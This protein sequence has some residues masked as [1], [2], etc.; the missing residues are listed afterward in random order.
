[1]SKNQEK[2][3][4]LFEEFSKT[5][6]ERLTGGI[7]TTITDDI[8]DDD[9]ETDTKDSTSDD[10][11]NNVQKQ[12]KKEKDIR[13]K[14]TKDTDDE[15][16]E[17]KIDEKEAK[18]LYEEY[19]VVLKN[20]QK[21]IGQLKDLQEKAE[22]VTSKKELNDLK[23]VISDL[24]EEGVI[25][26]FDNDKEISEYSL[27]EIQELIK[28]N[29]ENIK[30]DVIERFTSSLPEPIQMAIEY[31]I[32][33]KTEE[34][35]Q[36]LRLMA[37]A[38]E[39]KNALS[40]VSDEQKV[41]AWLMGKGIEEEE[42]ESLIRSYKSKGI[43]EDKL[44][45]AEKELD[46]MIKSEFQKTIEQKKQI[47]EQKDK[48]FKEYVEG[49]SK[50][51]SEM[52]LDKKVKKDILNGLTN[53]SYESMTGAK[54]NELYYLLEKYQFQD[55]KYDLVAKA[56]WLLK[57]PEGFENYVREN[58]KKDVIKSTIVPKLRKAEQTS[59]TGEDISVEDEI[60]IRKN[61]PDSIERLVKRPK[62]RF[63]I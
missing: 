5:P 48:A 62:F 2:Q 54:T 6:F 4:D 58:V 63:D 57:D 23:D 29:I 20:A 52:P 40:S 45:I 8:L 17:D 38:I 43:F 42:A 39:G 25:Y 16:F 59:K 37:D 27:Q 55:K 7:V 35:P 31:A 51:V 24:V 1:M 56:L 30:E 49:V 36:V 15:T 9:D 3:G 12:E 50:T 28:A 19:G 18:E 32:E 44:A 46:S 61:K 47:K 13:E 53:L 11:K 26:P 14:D 60:K 22:N 34:L 41:K 10:D 33:D 21:E